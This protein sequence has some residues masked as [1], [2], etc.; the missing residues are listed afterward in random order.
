MRC[1]DAGVTETKHTGARLEDYSHLSKTGQRVVARYRRRFVSHTAGAVE[2]IL[3][4]GCGQGWLLKETGKAHP[5]AKLTGIDM[6]PEALEFARGLVPSAEFV[7]Q[8]VHE[9]PFDDASFDLVICSDVL[10]HVETPATVV[11]EIRRVSRGFGVISVP[12]EPFFWAANLVRGKHL[13]TLGNYPEHVNHFGKGALR[14]LLEPEF[15]SVIIDTSFP[16]LIA[17][18]HDSSV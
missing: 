7:L 4:V 10:E 5:E 16:W 3:E 13:R 15:A 6:R 1:Y 2:S 9:L 14:R 11:H 17:E 8:D 12:H 18:V